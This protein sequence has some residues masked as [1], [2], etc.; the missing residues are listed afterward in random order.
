MGKDGKIPWNIPGELDRFKFLTTGNIVI[1]GRKTYEEIGRPLP[2][3]FNIVISG[4]KTFGG[5]KLFTVKSLD[6][7]LKKAEEIRKTFPEKIIYFAGGAKVY[8]K[9]LPL[10]QKLYITEINQEVEGDTFFPVFDKSNY[11]EEIEKISRKN[12]FTYLTYTKK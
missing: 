10:C 9:A 2:D 6:E 3:R 5:E 12:D 11:I 1:M 4:K 7:A 8:E